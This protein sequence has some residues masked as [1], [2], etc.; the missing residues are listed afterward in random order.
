M[1]VLMSAKQSILAVIVNYQRDE[2]TKSLVDQLL[3]QEGNFD[4]QVIVVN[5]ESS[6]SKQG[7]PAKPYDV[8]SNV[9]SYRTANLGYFGNAAWGVAKFLENRMLPDWVIVSNSDIAFT[10]NDALSLLLSYEK[11][12]APAVIAPTIIS[13]VTGQDQNP[14][15]R[16]RPPMYRM[17]FRKWVFRFY[18]TYLVYQLLSLVKRMLITLVEQ[19]TGAIKGRTSENPVSKPVKIYAPHGAFIIF[20]NSYFDAGGDFNYGAFL[21][22]EEIFVAEAVLNLGLSMVY[23]SR[24]EV[25]HKEHTATGTFKSREMVKHIAES[26]AYCANSFFR[27]TKA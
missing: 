8:R 21:F 19:I 2:E 18:A 17:H 13:G 27:K 16:N 5:C 15:M 3:T 25:V 22:G 6:G 24:L 4:L 10:D 23:D 14:F 7:S 12:G 26:S 1:K 9:F 20:H 11:K